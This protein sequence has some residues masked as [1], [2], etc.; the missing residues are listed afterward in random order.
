[1]RRLLL[2]LLPLAIASAL[3]GCDPYDGI[4]MEVQ[5]GP[6]LDVEF[7]ESGITLPVGI[8]VG[9]DISPVEG[10]DE[11]RLRVNSGDPTIFGLE[12]DI[13]GRYV[14]FGVTPGETVLRVRYRG[15]TVDRIPVTVTTQP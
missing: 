4:D 6:P 5:T 3:G 15:E 9:L 8:A 13:D 2:A 11:S 1:M 10:D 7:L 12:P 14:A